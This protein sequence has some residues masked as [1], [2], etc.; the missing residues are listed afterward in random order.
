MSVEQEKMEE[1]VESIEYYKKKIKEYELDLKRANRQITRLERDRKIMARM[2]EQAA[3]LRDYNSNEREKQSYYNSLLVENSPDIFVLLNTDLRIL[4]TTNCVYNIVPNLQH[5]IINLTI[6][7]AFCASLKPDNILA[8]EQCCLKVMETRKAMRFVQ[9]FMSYR[10][11]ERVFDTSIIP[12]LDKLEANVIGVVCVLRDITE[13]VKEKERAEQADKE[14]SIFLANMSHEIRTPMNAILGL[15]ECL[16]RDSNND[17]VLEYGYQI[18]NASNNLLAIINDIL[19]FSKIESGKLSIQNEVFHLSKAIKEVYSVLHLKMQEKNLD[20]SIEVDPH[21]PLNLVGDEGRLRQIILNLLS[22]AVKYTHAGKISLK[23]W[24]VQAAPDKVKLYCEVTDTGIGIKKEDYSKLFESFSRI[25]TKRNRSVEGTG[26]GLSICQRLAA[27]MDGE[28]YFTSSYG[29]GSTF[30]FYVCCGYEGLDEVGA[31]DSEKIDVKKNSFVNSY[32]IPEAKILIV[33]D[34]IVN[35][36]VI[37]NLLKPYEAKIDTVT[38]GYD[39]IEV[40]LANKGKYD[41]I[42]MDHM[43]PGMDGVEAMQEIRKLYPAANIIALTANAIDGA[44]NYYLQCGFNDYLTKPVVLQDLENVL[45]KFVPESYIKNVDRPQATMISNGVDRDIYKQVYLDIPK[46][47]KLYN[48]L[49]EQRDFENYTIQVHALKSVAKLIGYDDL[50][51]LARG[52]EAAGK[53]GN[54][55]YI[56]NDYPKLYNSVQGLFNDLKKMFADE[57]ENQ[58]VDAEAKIL[59]CAEKQKIIRDISAAAADFDL[60]KIE[61]LIKSFEG[62][63]LKPQEQKAIE[64]IQE[65]VFNFD[66]D[67]ITAALAKLTYKEE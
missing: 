40:I 67:S 1:A 54:Y 27:A 42:L 66:Y 50:S 16:L 51:E 63:K 8:F 20:F 55:T 6:Q 46:K 15:S 3:R 60:D 52:H 12:A 25:D 56:I 38:S 45:N 11:M 43:M 22:N 4:L 36:K 57:N 64:Q 34:N 41:L 48:E 9:K 30:G 37:V 23:L 18:K 28:L 21:I 44:K 29:V 47:L 17:T 7:E 33:D 2:S 39:A 10:N 19:D 24:S 31:F 26:L 59:S 32:I 62:V 61:E 49:I 58:N 53:N 65:A 5:N 35:L 14:K 13:L